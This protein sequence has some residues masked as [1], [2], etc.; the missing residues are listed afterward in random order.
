MCVEVCA[1]NCVCSAESIKPWVSLSLLPLSQPQWRV[2]ALVKL[3]VKFGDTFQLHANLFCYSTTF[4]GETH[5]FTSLQLGYLTAFVNYFE[6]HKFTHKTY[7]KLL[8][9]DAM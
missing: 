5:F 3:K 2:Y 6:D 1:Y 8:K 4:Q 7:D 9:C